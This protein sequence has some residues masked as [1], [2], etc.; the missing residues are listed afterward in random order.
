MGN[1]RLRSRS[2]SLSRAQQPSVVSE[3]MELLRDFIGIYSDK[4]FLDSRF[5][6]AT[7]RT[8]NFRDLKESLLRPRFSPPFL[9]SRN[10]VL[11]QLLY[12]AASLGRSSSTQS[13]F[14]LRGM[15]N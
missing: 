9:S 4:V 11:A 12:A 15:N 5:E 6:A 10:R 8:V 1:I 3:P 14:L 7:M 2:A 13:F